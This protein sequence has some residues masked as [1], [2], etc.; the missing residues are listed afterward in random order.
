MQ[1]HATYIANFFIHLCISFCS[2]PLPLAVIVTLVAGAL[3]AGVGLAAEGGDELHLALGRNSIHLRTSRRLTFTLT[4][5]KEVFQG[6]F[7]MIFLVF[8]DMFF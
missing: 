2:Y 8:F 4:F 5:E 7:G 3:G 6:F 1:D